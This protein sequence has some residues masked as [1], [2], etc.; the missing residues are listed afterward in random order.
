M[1]VTRKLES[2][3]NGYITSGPKNPNNFDVEVREVWQPWLK[4]KC[5]FVVRYIVPNRANIIKIMEAKGRFRNEVPIMI[6]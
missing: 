4:S 5:D 6:N 2:D 1:I 3:T